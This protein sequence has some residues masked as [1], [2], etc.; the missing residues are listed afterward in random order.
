[1]LKHTGVHNLSLKYFAWARSK[2][3]VCFICPKDN[4]THFVG[5]RAHFVALCPLDAGE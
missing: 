3:K 5:N 2:G 4:S 1:M